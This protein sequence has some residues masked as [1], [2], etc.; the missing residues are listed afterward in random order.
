M[1]D[2]N[3]FKIFENTET[4]VILKYHNLLKFGTRV[5]YLRYRNGATTSTQAPTY[6]IWCSRHAH[7]QRRVAQPYLNSVALHTPSTRQL[8]AIPCKIA[9]YD[10]SLAAGESTIKH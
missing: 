10:P 7:G 4:R 9:V 1:H 6:S 8:T 5:L 3:L 2:W